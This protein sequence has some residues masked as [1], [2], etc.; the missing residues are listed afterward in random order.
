MM[1]S[2]PT[3]FR[4]QG[5][6]S[7]QAELH[8]H[9]IRSQYSNLKCCETGAYSDAVDT[10]LMHSGVLVLVQTGDQDFVALWQTRGAF[11]VAS[12]GRDRL[13]HVHEQLAHHCLLRVMDGSPANPCVFKLIVWRTFLHQRLPIQS[14]CLGLPALRIWDFQAFFVSVAA[15]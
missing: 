3:T 2:E 8:W 4:L 1:G 7:N 11:W 12:P 14:Y 10:N 6:C 5:E 13:W 9:A 15:V